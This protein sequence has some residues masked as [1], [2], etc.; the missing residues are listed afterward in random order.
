MCVCVCVCE[1]VCV[2][3]SVCVFVCVGVWV[4]ERERES[5]CVLACVS[6]THLASPDAYPLALPLG[7]C[8]LRVCWC[9]RLVVL[10]I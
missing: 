9:C 10:K 5:V 8:F 1:S 4:S 3:E 2:R 7:A 6:H